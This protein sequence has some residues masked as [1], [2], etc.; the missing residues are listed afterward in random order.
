MLLLSSVAHASEVDIELSL[1]A[2]ATAA[3]VDEAQ[4]ESEM[5]SAID[6]Q[7]RVGD[8]QEYTGQMAD[9]NIL[10]AKGLGVDYGSDMQRF[11]AGGGF[12]TAVKGSSAGFTSGDAPLPEGG[13]AFQISAMAGLNLGIA[14]GDDSAARRFKIYAH[15]MSAT[16]QR[17]P[18]TGTF[19]NYGAHGQIKV[20]KGGEKGAALRWGGLDLTSGWEYSHYTLELTQEIP[21][22]SGDLGWKA[23]GTYRI[24]AESQSI[25]VELS[26]NL[27]VVVATA[28]VGGGV[29]YNLEGQGKTTIGVDGPLTYSYEGSEEK[30]GTA[31][32]SV[33]TT[34]QAA[35]ITPRF[36]VG[37]QADIVFIKVYGQLNATFDGSFGGHVGARV[38]L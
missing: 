11:A 20:I 4:L 6:S 34:G 31:A 21:V 2:E 15:G 14:A 22:E 25:P 10:S 12:G 24:E 3:G 36:F 26:T 35:A 18:F 19:L 28:W 37:A 16:T 1:P 29:D 23:E 13:F 7:L 33:G 5:R 32:V 27:H 9:A 17:D 38:V 30:V 8:L